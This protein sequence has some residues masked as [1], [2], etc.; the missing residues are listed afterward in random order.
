MGHRL[1]FVVIAASPAHAF[2][3]RRTGDR[4]KGHALPHKSASNQGWGLVVRTPRVLVFGVI[5][6]WGK[7]LAVDAVFC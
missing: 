1:F 4:T 2:A 6:R 7:M 3:Y 5:F